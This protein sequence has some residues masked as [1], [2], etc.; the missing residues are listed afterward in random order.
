MIKITLFA[1][2]LTV[3]NLTASSQDALALGNRILGGGITFSQNDSENVY[4]LSTT[5]SNDDRTYNRFSYSF[6]PYYGRFYKDFNMVG[7]RLNTRGS[8]S[9]FDYRDD[10]RADR[11][12]FTYTS[13]S[14]GG[15]FRRYFPY[16]D[17]FGVFLETGIDGYRSR[18]IELRESYD[19]DV[20]STLIRSRF[21]DE[22]KSLGISVDAKV[23]LY[24]FL[25]DRLSLETRLSRFYL[26]YGDV[27]LLNVDLVNNEQAE[28]EGSNSSIDFSFVNN[29]SF[30]QIFTINYYF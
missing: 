30:D 20:S 2:L 3:L 8:N 18:S 21:E 22:R 10:I 19:I 1:S 7:L 25:L 4:R 26:S 28:A 13:F 12:E 9:E 5:L 29:F 23:G 6:S 17:K 15:F 14:I 11:T 24:F 16:S 27:Q